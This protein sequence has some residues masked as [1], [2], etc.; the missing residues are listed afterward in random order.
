M[1]VFIGCK[2]VEEEVEVVEPVEVII[3]DYSTYFNG[4]EGSFV[5]FNPVKNDYEI[6][7]EALASKELSPCSTFKIYNALIG[8]E[9]GVA[10]GK[11]YKY[12]WD[13]TEYD[14]KAWNQDHTL[15]SAMA[16]SVVWYYQQ[17]AG[18][19]GREVMTKYI[20]DMNYGNKDIS[21]G[22]ME[23]WLDSS[24]K[25]SPRQ[26]VDLLKKLYEAQLPF[27]AD[28]MLKVQEMIVLEEDTLYELSGKTGTAPCEVA[29][30]VGSILKD[31]QRYYFATNLVE[32]D[33]V[34]GLMAKEITLKILADLQLY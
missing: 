25:I 23:F 34:T 8:L 20:N 29:W 13:G 1:V 12:T 32:S 27:S 6:Y 7:N 5:L 3:D 22:L 28:N 31:D 11:E 18:E 14:M 24:L 10:S 17:L 26:Q 30:F 33:K 4:M 2:S 19:I 16:Y 21:G 15:E 9:S